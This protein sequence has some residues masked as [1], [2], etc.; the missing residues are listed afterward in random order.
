MG[1]S[2]QKV[3]RGRIPAKSKLNLLSWFRSLLDGD[4]LQCKRCDGGG[5]GVIKVAPQGAARPFRGVSLARSVAHLNVHLGH[6]FGHL[7]Y[8]CPLHILGKVTS[9]SEKDV[10]REFTVFP[11]MHSNTFNTE[12]IVMMVF[13]FS[14]PPSETPP[15]LG[16]WPS[17]ISSSPSPRNA[18]L[19]L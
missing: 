9:V 15:P 18:S 4:I 13:V 12:E 1:I 8:A 3:G 6:K 7:R 10:Y 16:R 17:A 11:W 14:K 19:I 5:G 2:R